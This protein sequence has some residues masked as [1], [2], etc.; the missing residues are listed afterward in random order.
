MKWTEEWPDEWSILFSLFAF[1]GTFY[2]KVRL[3]KWLSLLQ[4]EGFPVK[5]KFIAAEMGPHDKA[6]DRQAENLEKRGLLTIEQKE[7]GHESPIYIYKIT[8]NGKKFTQ[9]KIMPLLNNMPDKMA[10]K[11]SYLS[12]KGA[13]YTKTPN[14]I[15]N[16]HKVLIL[17]DYA[18]FYNE[19]C[20]AQKKVEN[21]FLEMERGFL[22]FCELY[23][24][25]LAFL[26][27]TNDSLKIIIDERSRDL[28]VGKN[29]VLYNAIGLISHFEKMSKSVAN[30]QLKICRQEKQCLKHPCPHY[31]ELIRHRF[32]CIEYNS[33]LYNI[34]A[35]IDYET[36]D[37]KKLLKT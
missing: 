16:V 32:R 36:A 2:G 25:Y 13:M 17:D 9:E 35:A 34:H 26:E 14:L 3:N 37:F 5:N 4:R 15:D 24:D 23:L 31:D 11:L 1:K 22:D 18:Q 30:G 28:H 7:I 8:E 21:H 10:F 20:S 33:D 29:H 27:F 12:I 6:I 19:L